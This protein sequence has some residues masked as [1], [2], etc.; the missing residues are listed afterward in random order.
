MRLD[1]YG[2]KKY[3]ALECEEA[4]KGV[5]F[6]APGTIPGPHTDGDTIHVFEPNALWN[7]D[8]WSVWEYEVYHEIGHEAPENC[9]PHW[10]SVVKANKVGG[11]T[12]LFSLYNLVSDHV[13]EH[14][15]VGK[16]VGRD[17]VLKRGRANFVVDRLLDEKKM[18]GSEPTKNASIFK[19]VAIYDTYCRESWNSY[20]S[21][22]SR[23]A[24][25]SLDG[26]E[27]EIWEKLYKSGIKIEDQ[28]NEDEA[29]LTAKRILDAIGEDS[30]AHEEEAQKQY[31]KQSGEGSESSDGEPGEAGESGVGT[32]SEAD[33]K[34]MEGYVYHAHYEKPEGE[35]SY[36]S[37]AGDGVHIDYSKVTKGDEFFPN[38]PLIVD[39]KNGKYAGLERDDY[40]RSYAKDSIRGVDGGRMLAGQ[41]KRLLISMKQLRWEHGQKR[42]HISSKNLWKARRPVYSSE[43][44]KKRTSQI[45]LNTAVTVLTDNS[46]SMA[47][48]KFA[49][50]AR[51]GIMLNEAMSK[52][53]VPVE[54]LSF[55]ECRQGP[56]NI[57]VK[58]F[59]DRASEGELVERYSECGQWMWQNSDG[60]SIMW[61]ATR[62]AKRPE[63]RKVLIVLSDGSPAAYNGGH[64]GEYIY[65]K[66]IVEKIESSP[67]EI[68]GIGIMD[69]NV[70]RIYKDH[71]V[72]KKSKDLEDMLLGLVKSKLLKS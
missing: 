17:R 56:V 28:T 33:E 22:V 66:R 35:S 52:I 40:Y 36:P 57:I 64:G 32:L 37:G 43:V 34:A 15:R 39:I 61:A 42:G 69:S 50:A 20:L 68:Y 24:A 44:F 55:S 19:V 49:H 4:G 71:K 65:T 54:L 31:D 13:Q 18:S 23:P 2:A 27:A 16:Y 3:V 58:G 72:L 62:L 26:Y 63:K 47:G 67:I 53:G 14:N 46:G 29:Y 38:D 21:G 60:E 51:A 30:E 10:K 41:V 45:E 5:V 25:D 7:E 9:S 12:L 59:N 11:G 8:E 70:E 1:Y 48:S 6:H